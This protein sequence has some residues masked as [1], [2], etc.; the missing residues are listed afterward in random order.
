VVGA[1]DWIRRLKTDP[2]FSIDG[3][4]SAVV[5]GGGN[6]AVDVARELAALGVATV[7]LV[8][9]RGRE[10]MKAYA[11]E[12]DQARQAGVVLIAAAAVAEVVR[13]DGQVTGV[14]LV[15]TDDGRPT[16]RNRGDLAA[17]LVVT[18][19]GQ[20]KLAA[21]AT[22]F[23]GVDCDN[24]GCIVIDADTGATGNP[25][26]FAG[27]D[28]VNGGKEVVNA[29]HDGQAAADAMDALFQNDSRTGGDDA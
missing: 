26:V 2:T 17:D 15:A 29:V 6:T 4:R 18:A 9:R 28:A 11:H 12:L 7:T 23:P 19:I 1:I 20:E 16:D 22:Q 27:G 13:R 24:R 8:Y 3:V 10:R 25:Q 5:V 21:L 14:R